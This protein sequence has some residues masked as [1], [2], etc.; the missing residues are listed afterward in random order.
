MTIHRSGRFILKGTPAE[1][2]RQL[3]EMR[4]AEERIQRKDPKA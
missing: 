4:A 2:A 1:I 3:A